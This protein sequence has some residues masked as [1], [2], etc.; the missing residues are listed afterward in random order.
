MNE[1]RFTLIQRM[2]NNPDEN[3]WE[4]FDRTYRAYIIGIVRKLN[5]DY[6]ENEDLAQM[7]MLKLW[8]GLE[9]FDYKPGQCK[10]RSW[11]AIV[12]RNAVIQN[13]QLNRNK[14]FKKM[15][16][17]V[18]IENTSLP[19][20][21]E[22]AFEEWKE[23]ILQKAME[24]TQAQFTEQVFDIFLKFSNGMKPDDIAEETGV[25]SNTVYVYKKRIEAVLKKEI[26]RLNQELD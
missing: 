13:A 16:G 12:S 2:K 14:M 10:F 9:N 11:V 1:T 7:I 23:F 5:Y 3:S 20:I 19:E 26:L 4:D 6:H 17:G 22:I 18:E 21:E 25:A 15:D 24:A 8:K